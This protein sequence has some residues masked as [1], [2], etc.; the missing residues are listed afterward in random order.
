MRTTR[1]SCVIKLKPNNII[2]SMNL[3]YRKKQ[4]VFEQHILET[5]FGVLYMDTHL[6]PKRHDRY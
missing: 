4:I 1:L 5:D 3:V 2:M 6:L